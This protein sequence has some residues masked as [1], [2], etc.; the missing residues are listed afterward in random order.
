MNLLK[1]SII[2]FLKK[3]KNKSKQFLDKLKKE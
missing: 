3:K 2:L 1:N